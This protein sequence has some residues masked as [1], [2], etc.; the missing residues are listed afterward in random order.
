MPELI[1]KKVILCMISSTLF[2]KNGLHVLS[3][4]HSK[5]LHICRL[6]NSASFS[7][8]LAQVFWEKSKESENTLRGP[9]L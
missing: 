9:G 6:Y 3:L 5:S 8:I 2:S 4:R 7:P 1:T